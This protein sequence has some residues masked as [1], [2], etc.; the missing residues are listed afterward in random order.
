MTSREATIIIS[1]ENFMQ[2]FKDNQIK[3]Y[4]KKR[5]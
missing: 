3:I 5:N 4:K 1:S 2:R